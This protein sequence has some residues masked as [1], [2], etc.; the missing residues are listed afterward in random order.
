M[1]IAPEVAAPNVDRPVLTISTAALY[2]ATVVLA[3]MD[4]LLMIEGQSLAVLIRKMVKDSYGID[5]DLNVDI[6]VEDTNA[7]GST[8]TVTE[9]ATF[10]PTTLEDRVAVLETEATDNKANV[11]ALT[12]RVI[13]VEAEVAAIKPAAL[14]TG[15]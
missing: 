15:A 9:A 6:L 8:A 1:H 2:N 5:V 4:H 13:T 12:D 10:D 3:A 7:D 11:V 14:V